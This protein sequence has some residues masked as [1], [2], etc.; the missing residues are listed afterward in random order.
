MIQNY[1]AFDAGGSIIIENCPKLSAK[2]L[3]W[4]ENEIRE[5]EFGYT[6]LKVAMATGCTLEEYYDYEMS[7]SCFD[8]DLFVALEMRKTGRDI[9]GHVAHLEG[10]YE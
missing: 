3:A 7:S 9:R 2:G 8:H 4:V 10:M 6:Q 1:E 5:L